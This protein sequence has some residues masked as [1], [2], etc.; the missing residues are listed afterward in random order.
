MVHGQ[1]RVST[2]YHKGNWYMVPI[3]QP[4]CSPLPYLHLIEVYNKSDVKRQITLGHLDQYM[5]QQCCI[6]KKSYCET[7]YVIILF[8]SN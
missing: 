4:W 1:I 7:V 6:V 8:N 3:H 2:F 5:S